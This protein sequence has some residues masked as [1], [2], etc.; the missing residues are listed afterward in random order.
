MKNIALVILLLF[1]SHSCVSQSVTLTETEKNIIEPIGLK[2]TVATK[3]KALASS[4]FEISEGNLDRK[5]IHEDYEEL[6]DYENNLP[7]AIMIKTK[8]DEAYEIIEAYRTLLKKNNIQVYITDQNYGYE[9]DV[10]S[11][12]VSENKYEPLLFEATNAVN[13]DIYTLEIIEK[14]KKWDSLYGLEIYGIGFDFVAGTFKNL[15]NDVSELAKEMYEFCP[16]IVD[17]GTGS[18]KELEIEIKNSNSL[19]LWWD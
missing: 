4:E 14:L 3:I 12:L 6:S 5:W 15:P 19:F 11:F 8:S 10:V 9:D 17:Q 13:Y 2:E 7:K 1:I 16:D 18:V